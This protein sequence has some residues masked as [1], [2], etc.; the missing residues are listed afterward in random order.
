MAY[1]VYKI[2]GMDADR[3]FEHYA[4]YA[5]FKQ[6]KQTARTLRQQAQDDTTVKIIF[7]DSRDEAEARLREVRKAPIL[8][9]WEK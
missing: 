2:V 1:F 5:A 7:A 4:D 9:E 8:K 3:T 6:A